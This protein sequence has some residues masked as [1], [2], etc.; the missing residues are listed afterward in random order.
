LDQDELTKPVPPYRS[1]RG[2]ASFECSDHLIFIR[3]QNS[4]SQAY[5]GW[6]TAAFLLIFP[7]VR[8]SVPGRAWFA[9]DEPGVA[10]WFGLFVY[11]FAVFACISVGFRWSTIR[12]DLASHRIVREGRWGPFRSCRTAFVNEFDRVAVKTDSD[13]VTT[14]ELVGLHRLQIVWGRSRAESERLA[15]EFAART[16]LPMVGGDDE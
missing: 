1:R 4:R 2:A 3:N 10:G 7:L 13:H 6:A 15:K 8:A 14:V 5:M 12:V 16:G 9:F 11:T